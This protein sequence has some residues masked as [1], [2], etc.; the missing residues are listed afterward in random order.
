[1]NTSRSVRWMGKDGVMAA[2]KNANKILIEKPE[3][4]RPHG[5]HR[6]RWEATFKIHLK[7]IG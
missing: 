5:R 6:R 7:E 3:W 1:M 4:K 2:M